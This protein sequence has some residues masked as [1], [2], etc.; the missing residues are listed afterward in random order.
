MEL[1]EGAVIGS[2]MKRDGRTLD[3]AAL[4][5]IR[6]M[7]VEQIREGE[8]PSAVIA[9]CGF[10]RTTVYKWLTAVAQPG[11]GLKARTMAA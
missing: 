9:S 2:D 3:R 6:Q 7:A 4:E 10:N 1:S 8:S 5:I 11:I